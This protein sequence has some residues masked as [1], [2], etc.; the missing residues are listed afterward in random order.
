MAIAGSLSVTPLTSLSK[1]IA[2]SLVSDRLIESIVTQLGMVG[3]DY[4]QAQVVTS[5]RAG[6]TTI[7][8]APPSATF[9]KL[10]LSEIL[11]EGEQ[12]LLALAAFFAELEVSGH[13]GPLVLDDPVTGLDAD[14]KT[15]DR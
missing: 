11:S 4:I 13:R 12:A 10:G 7:R 14:N 8:L 2:T 3:L 9:K 5:G 6:V 1:K 15:S